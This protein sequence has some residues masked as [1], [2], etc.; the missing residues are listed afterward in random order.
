MERTWQRSAVVI[1]ALAVACTDDVEERVERAAPSG[2]TE[3]TSR[4]CWRTWNSSS[5]SWASSLDGIEVV[6][7]SV[8]AGG[9]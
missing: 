9:P 7:P 5:I 6:T 4:P 1:L 2:A 3:S 8:A